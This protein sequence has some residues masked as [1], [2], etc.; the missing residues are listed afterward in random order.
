[1]LQV[2]GLEQA[3][4]H[5][6]EECPEE[7]KSSLNWEDE[8]VGAMDEVNVVLVVSPPGAGC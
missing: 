6:L 8:F 1:M 2:R 3:L 7:T 4:E 5:K